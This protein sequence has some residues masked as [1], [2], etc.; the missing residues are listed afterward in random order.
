MKRGIWGY[1]KVVLACLM[2]GITTV[3]FFGLGQQVY[4]QTEREME[5]SADNIP[6]D[7][8][9]LAAEKKYPFF[10]G[11]SYVT[12][13]RNYQGSDGVI[14]F[15]R[16]DALSFVKAYEYVKVDGKDQL[17]EIARERIGVYPFDSATQEERVDVTST[18]KHTIRYWVEGESGLKAE[19]IMMV[20][21]DILPEGEEY[22]KSEVVYENG[23]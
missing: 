13:N 19:M 6:E 11:S 14:G 5:E 21:V 12:I 18:G 17:R 10:V 8:R 16:E 23:H 3:V 22:R 7:M 1:G 20:L 9:T 15:S 2:A 4:E